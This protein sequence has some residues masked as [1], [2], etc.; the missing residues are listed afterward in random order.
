M[1]TT[2]ARGIIPVVPSAS[3]P[4]IN[5][6]GL[7]TRRHYIDDPNMRVGLSTPGNHLPADG[8]HGRLHYQEARG[9]EARPEGTMY[10]GETRSDA[11]FRNKQKRHL[12]STNRGEGEPVE[13]DRKK[14]TYLEN[15][16]L[17]KNC[18]FSEREVEKQM[19]M[20]SRVISARN[21]IPYMQVRLFLIATAGCCCCRRQSW[22]GRC[23]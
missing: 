4:P 21:G 20:K 13:M 14:Q 15:G 9:T 2:A 16:K 19:G 8:G 12:V 18:Q 22:P 1:Y 5:N 7:A 10:I 23:C 17:L 6:M 11:E 3:D